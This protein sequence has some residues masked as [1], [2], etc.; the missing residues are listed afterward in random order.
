[1][2]LRSLQMAVQRGALWGA[3]ALTVPS[4]TLGPLPFL[5]RPHTTC[6]RPLMRPLLVPKARGAAAFQCAPFST[7]E[8]EPVDTAKWMQDNEVLGR[9][10]VWWQT[11]LMFGWCHDS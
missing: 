3:R 1:M 2:S 6:A 9:A 8:R 11:E 10:G 4:R 5:G 7:G